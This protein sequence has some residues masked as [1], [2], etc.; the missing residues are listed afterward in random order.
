MKKGEGAWTSASIICN[1]SIVTAI[2]MT[3]LVGS[4]VWWLLS[5]RKLCSWYRVTVARY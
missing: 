1:L 2:D 5:W 3:W 4:L